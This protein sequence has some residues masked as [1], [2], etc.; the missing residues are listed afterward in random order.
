MVLP[1]R[2]HLGGCL[3]GVAIAVAA[4]VGPPAIAQTA[5][6]ERLTALTIPVFDADVPIGTISARISQGGDYRIPVSS[7]LPILQPLYATNEFSVISSRLQGLAEIGP[8]EV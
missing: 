2:R 1:K 3:Y 7:L 5:P 4:F 8:A 6:S